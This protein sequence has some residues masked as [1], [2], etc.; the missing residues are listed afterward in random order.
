MSAA[1]LPPGAKG[2]VGLAADHGGYALKEHL[3]GLL[4]ADGF[5]VMDFGATALRPEDDFPDFVAPL[6]RAVAAGTVARGVALCGSGV[7]A[8]VVAN[9]VPGVRAC[10][11]QDPFAARQGV[12]DD[13]L[14]VLCLGGLVTGPALAW[15][16]VRIFLAARFSGGERFRRRLD[17]VA[18]VE[19]VTR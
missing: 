19:A 13:D 5:Q 3:A 9:K 15:E 11:I 8:C 18:G 16:L 6:A 12:A 10:L 4:R 17:K 14:N 7:G 1:T 2:I